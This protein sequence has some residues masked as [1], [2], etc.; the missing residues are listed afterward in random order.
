MKSAKELLVLV[1]DFIFKG[2][3]GV[4]AIILTVAWKILD[5]PQPIPSTYSNLLKVMFTLA[6]GISAAFTLWSMKRV[7]D[8]DPEAYDEVNAT[9]FV[10]LAVLW[11][12]W[13]AFT[14]QL[15]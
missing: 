7:K 6:M 15:P 10:L 1:L 11:A 5:G 3:V 13:V 4:T 2:V 9:V 14:H 12:V 8:A